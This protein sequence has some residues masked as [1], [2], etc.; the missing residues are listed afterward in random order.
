MARCITARQC[1]SNRSASS[2]VSAARICAGVTSAKGGSPAPAPPAT[3]AVTAG[4]LPLRGGGDLATNPPT[5][6]GN[7]VIS[8]RSIWQCRELRCP[9]WRRPWIQARQSALPVLGPRVVP[10]AVAGV[11][12]LLPTQSADDRSGRKEGLGHAQPAATPTFSGW[13]GLELVAPLPISA[14]RIGRS[15][16]PSS[17]IVG[18]Y[19]ARVAY[20]RLV[21]DHS[22][23]GSLGDS[24]PQL[25]VEGLQPGVAP[26]ALTA[27][28][29]DAPYVGPGR[30]RPR[31]GGWRARRPGLGRAPRR[32][33]RSRADAPPRGPR[34]RARPPRRPSASR[35]SGRA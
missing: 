16:C 21:G 34:S 20:W 18:A 8:V 24:D 23:V 29:L 5:W 6:L 13:V 30:V 35:R 12:E 4:T 14:V 26:A 1:S 25:L 19:D 22:I 11:D 15:A 7:L 17:A 9:P 27:R 32:R 10:I 3:G 33:R 2:L 31:A 28:V